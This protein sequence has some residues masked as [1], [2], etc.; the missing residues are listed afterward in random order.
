MSYF[1]WG[2]RGNLKLITLGSERVNSTSLPS[3]RQIQSS[4]MDFQDKIA[5]EFLQYLKEQG[6]QKTMRVDRLRAIY[7][8]EY[9]AETYGTTFSS[10]LDSLSFCLNKLQINQGKVTFGCGDAAASQIFDSDDDSDSDEPVLTA[11]NHCPVCKR[12]FRSYSGLQQHF[13]T[14]RH[15]Q[16]SIVCSIKKSLDRWVKLFSCIPNAW[17]VKV[18]DLFRI[19]TSTICW[20]E[21]T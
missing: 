5:L 7:E 11:V 4:R 1:W 12:D 18:V 15:R 13:S 6:H 19:A 20:S 8:V 2:C 9:E 16:Q 17:L 10:V 3:G 14:V 21:L